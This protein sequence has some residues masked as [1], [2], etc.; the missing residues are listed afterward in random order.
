M[1]P[2]LF[3]RSTWTFLAEIPEVRADSRRHPYTCHTAAESSYAY[4]GLNCPVPPPP[5]APKDFRPEKHEPPRQPGHPGV[6]VFTSR[7]PWLPTTARARGWPR[8]LPPTVPTPLLRW[9]L[10]VRRAPVTY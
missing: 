2:A 1:S 4:G 5:R 10:L 7:C 9:Q 6:P 8:T 3:L